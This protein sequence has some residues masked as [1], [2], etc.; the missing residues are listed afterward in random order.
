MTGWE[1]IESIE[2]QCN[3]EVFP[4]NLPSSYPVVKLDF[5]NSNC[6]GKIEINNSGAESLELHFGNKEIK[7]F[8]EIK[9][10]SGREI[11]VIIQDAKDVYLKN[12]TLEGVSLEIKVNDSIY[13]DELKQSDDSK[14][15]SLNGISKDVFLSGIISIKGDVN[16]N[17]IDKTGKI[18]TSKLKKLSCSLLE[19]TGVQG[20]DLYGET[21]GDR[22]KITGSEG[23]FNQYGNIR[24]KEVDVTFKD[25]YIRG[26]LSVVYGWLRSFSGEIGILNGGNINILEAEEGEGLKILSI[27]FKLEKGGEIN[28]KRLDLGAHSY[29]LDGK[30]GLNQWKCN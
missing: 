27:K 13:V 4:I 21:V 14:K 28:G 23:R 15:S 19:L 7:I 20:L 12:I 8:D 16:F 17:L 11:K 24:F 29:E 1:Y 5:S 25:I 30:V 10:I 26:Q 9:V 18:E 3:Q 6:I 22:L 2:W